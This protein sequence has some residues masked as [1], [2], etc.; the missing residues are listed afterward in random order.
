MHVVFLNTFDKPNEEGGIVSA[1][2]SICE[3]DGVWSVLWMEGQSEPNC[4]F[5]GT[6]WEE[7]LVAF[8]HGVAVKMGEC[9]SPVID[10]ML[11][12]KRGGAGS[13]ISMLQC[14]GELHANIELFE[15]LR[16]WRRTRASVE[17]K[18]AYLIATNRMLWMISAFV[19]YTPEELLQIPGWGESKH[20]AFGAE[21]LEVTKKAARTKGFPLNWV[22]SE[23]NP[24]AFTQWLYKQKELKYKNDMIKNEQKKRILSFVREG[25]TIEQLQTELEMPRR[26]IMDRIEQL[27]A[28]GY[29][30]DPLIVRELSDMPEDE[31]NGI[32]QAFQ[33]TGDRYLKP[34]LQQVYGAE[35][36]KDKQ[37]DV[38]YERL[39][40]VRLSYRK[41]RENGKAIS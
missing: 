21:V 5:E 33:Q 8:R 36:V 6:S 30:F 18:S 17:K 14:Y 15:A 4:W 1:Q 10:S 19:P 40:L 41:E 37:V 28:E 27:D 24:A 38:L 35:G 11:E 29:D 32:W 20:N 25:G 7:M 9:Y 2:L 12:E 31:R 34:V 22:A 23:L 26:E 3:K 13:F 39:R 16:E